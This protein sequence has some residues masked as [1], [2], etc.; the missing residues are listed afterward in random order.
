MVKRLLCIILI[1]LLVG[2]SARLYVKAPDGT[3]ITLEN[4]AIT[5]VYTPE[6]KLVQRMVIP[7]NSM[8]AN[9]LDKLAAL[10]PT[11]SQVMK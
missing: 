2:C 7:D 5:E 1:L 8:F 10:W 6:G 4:Y 11:F 3:E 9:I